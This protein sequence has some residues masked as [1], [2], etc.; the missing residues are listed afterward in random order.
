MAK[1][2]VSHRG[3][4]AGPAERLAS[5]LRAAGHDVWL[6]AWEIEVG[7]SVVEKIDAGL[8]SADFLVLCLS[9]DADGV[10]TAWMLREWAPTLAR[11][12]AGH[13]VTILPVVL[14]GG[15]LPAVLA[16]IKTADLVADWPAGVRALLTAIDAIGRRASTR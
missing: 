13:G 14:T 3:V 15:E 11:Q 2:F 5:E 10:H 12:L 7:D 1:L 4:D 16:D 8:T 9:V 6:D